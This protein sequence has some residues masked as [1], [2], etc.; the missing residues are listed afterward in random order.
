M[1][2]LWLEVTALVDILISTAE[3]S[4][5]NVRFPCFFK[6]VFFHGKYQRQARPNYCF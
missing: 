5:K 1:V 3:L 4:L 6:Q 2:G